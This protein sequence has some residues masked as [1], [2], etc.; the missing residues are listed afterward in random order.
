MSHYSSVLH[1]SS[2]NFSLIH[3]LLWTKWSHQS[4]NFHGFKCLVKI[5]LDQNSPDSCQFWNNKLIFL[6]ILGHSSVS[7]DITPTYFFRWNCNYFQQKETIKVQIWW[8]FT[9]AVISLE[10]CILPGSFCPNHTKFLLKKHRRVISHE[11]EEWC[12]V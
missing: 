9:W 7:W 4:P 2:V 10:F 5:C 3:F 1:N 8:N 12:K 11:T 6:Q